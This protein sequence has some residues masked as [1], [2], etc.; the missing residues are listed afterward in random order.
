MEILKEEQISEEYAKLLQDPYN[1][2]QEH[3]E[4]MYLHIGKKIWSVLSLV[5]VSLIAPKFILNNREIRM[6]LNFMLLAGSGA[7]K[8]QTAKEF[9]KIAS[10]PIMSRNMTVPRLY[11]EL[12]KKKGKKIS[13]IV[14]DVSVWFMD[15]EKIKFL[16]GITGEEESYSRETMKNVNDDKDKHTDLVSF[17][18]GTPE[19]ITQRR[20]KDGILRRFFT[21]MIIL[22][23]QENKD[24]I[25]FILNGAT[26]NRNTKDSEEIVKFYRELEQIQE[27]NHPKI[28]QIEGYIY[29]G[30]AK[31]Q[32][33]SEFLQK[34]TSPLLRHF[35]HN[36]A[37]ESEEFFRLATSHAFLNIHKK[38]RHNQIIENKLVIDDEDLSVAKELIAKEISTKLLVYQ[39]IYAIDV[40]GLRTT[41]Q[42]RRWEEKRKKTGKGELSKGARMILESNLKE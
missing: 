9:E 28:P 8:S 33:I 1:Y 11:S 26:E 19:N 41:Q 18:S 12:K 25:N 22:S 23:E 4:S 10:T 2:I 34:I 36:S 14:E 3:Y 29:P 40:L 16:E 17:C 6:H 35:N 27:G 30:K 24:I 20:L 21:M 37:T 7:A 32:E 13:L 42:L 5:P 31:M 15:E 39:C 38:Q